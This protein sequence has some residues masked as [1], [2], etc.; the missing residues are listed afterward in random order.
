MHLFTLLNSFL[1]EVFLVGRQAVIWGHTNGCFYL[2]DAEGVRA[3]QR[4]VGLGSAPP[5]LPGPAPPVRSMS[6]SVSALLPLA[7]P[8]RSVPERGRPLCL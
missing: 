3:G 7:E 4:S 5:F 6:V 2:G 1:F 8:E